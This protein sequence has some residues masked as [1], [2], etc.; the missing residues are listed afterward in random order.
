[1]F[2]TVLPDLG[3]TGRKCPIYCFCGLC[4]ADTLITVLSRAENMRHICMDESHDTG[5]SDS[6]GRECPSMYF[7]VIV[8][9]TKAFR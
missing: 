2:W 8:T 5:P 1:M 3:A 7:V 4:N 6:S 9:R